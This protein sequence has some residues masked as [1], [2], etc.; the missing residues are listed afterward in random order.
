M[1]EKKTWALRL[2]EYLTG[3]RN[4]EALTLGCEFLWNLSEVSF[5]L[6]PLQTLLCNLRYLTLEVPSVKNCMC[7]MIYLL[8]NV[9]NIE[10][11]VFKTYGGWLAEAEFWNKEPSYQK[12]M[13]TDW[14]E[15]LL[16]DYSI[17]YKLRT[18]EFKIFLGCN[19]EF[20]ILK[21][22]LK[23]AKCL[24][25]IDIIASVIWGGYSK[26]ICKQLLVRFVIS[27]SFSKYINI[28]IILLNLCSSVDR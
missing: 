13:E 18:I 6:E 17:L 12:I 8:Q 21:L 27:T 25:K 10:A 16:F 14:E 15:N 7:G 28:V 4:V 26:K 2:M 5:A 1:D 22:L 11:L 23:A 9:P 19:S 24:E 20:R 3:L